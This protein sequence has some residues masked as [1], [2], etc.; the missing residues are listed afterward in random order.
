[1]P[2]RPNPGR[3]PREAAGKR[4]RVVLADGWDSKDR[5]PDGWQANTTNWS[6][7]LGPHSVE[8]WEIAS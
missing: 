7:E 8:Q 1:M 5:E 6:R 3:C 4:V 2:L